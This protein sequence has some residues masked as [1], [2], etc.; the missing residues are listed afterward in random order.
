MTSAR[1]I[2]VEAVPE[3]LLEVGAMVWSRVAAVG[4]GSFRSPGIGGHTPLLVERKIQPLMTR[5][6]SGIL[7]DRTAEP[8]PWT[9]ESMIRTLGLVGAISFETEELSSC[10]RNQPVRYDEI[11][12]AF[13]AMEERPVS[14]QQYPID[15]ASSGLLPDR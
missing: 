9:L 2:I 1:Q 13:L 4:K 8:H 7:Q 14:I 3:R 5:S 10:S 11:S 15:R 12:P 6:K